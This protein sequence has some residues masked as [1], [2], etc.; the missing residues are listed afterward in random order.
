LFCRKLEHPITHRYTEIQEFPVALNNSQKWNWS[1]RLFLTE[2]KMNL[3]K[4][5]EGGEPSKYTQEELDTL[6][7]TLKE[8]ETWLNNVVEKQ[9]LVKMYEDPAV[10]S[11][12]LYAKA[13]VLENHLQRLVKKKVPKKKTSTSASPSSSSTATSSAGE[14]KTTPT[15]TESSETGVHDEL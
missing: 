3:A 11:T 8:H 5:A 6:E 10:E 14:S 4:E 2:A 13:K 15:K 7:K 9:K 12:E 1:T